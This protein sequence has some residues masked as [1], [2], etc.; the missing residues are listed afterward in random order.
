MAKAKKKSA[1]VRKTVSTKKVAS[2]KKTMTPHRGGTKDVVALTSIHPAKTP[3]TKTEIMTLLADT[4][5]LTKR[6][7]IA[8]FESLHHLVG[9]DMGGK[10]CGMFT[11][12]GLLKIRRVDRPATKARQGVNPFTKEE[13][14]FKAKPARSVVKVR[15]LKSL[16]DMV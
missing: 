15:P 12:P 7:V 6:E 9:M 10:G 8:L 5:G 2:A 3:R 14:T 11:I 16:K 4:T 1:S 13:T